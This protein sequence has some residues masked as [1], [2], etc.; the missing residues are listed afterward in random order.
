ME[1][2]R[3]A[4]ET[5]DISYDPKAFSLHK[6]GPEQ[7]VLDLANA[8][9]AYC[10]ASERDRNRMFRKWIRE[11]FAPEHEEADVTDLGERSS[12]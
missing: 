5:A 12:E 10:A 6:Q 4:G 9:T 7:P 11:W 8:Y 1:D 2:V 3:K